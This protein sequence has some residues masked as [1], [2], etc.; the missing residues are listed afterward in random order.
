MGWGFDGRLADTFQLMLAFNAGRRQEPRFVVWS[1]C[2]VHPFSA[3]NT[4]DY[5]NRTHRTPHLVWDPFFGRILEVTPLDQQALYLSKEVKQDTIQ[6]VVCADDQLPF[7]QQPMEG[8]ESLLETFR[9]L[10]VPQVFPFGIPSRYVSS[11]AIRRPSEPGHYS[12]DQLDPDLDGCG[13]IDVRILFGGCNGA[14]PA[15]ERSA[16][17]SGDG[18]PGS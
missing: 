12:A 9:R 15:R 14:N 7:T 5:L 3:V 17:W 1:V 16:G 10:G 2:S 6:V 4:V 8:S 13:P 18:N 11:T